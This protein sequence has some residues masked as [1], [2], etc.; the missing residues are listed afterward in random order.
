M[1]VMNNDNEPKMMVPDVR[2]FPLAQIRAGNNARTDFDENELAELVESMRESREKIGSTLQ[3]LLGRLMPDGMVELIAGER[4]MRAASLAGYEEM[5][6]KVVAGCTEA[7]VLRWNLVENLQ[8]S[9]LKPMEVARRVKE[10]LALTVD[11][12]PVYNQ[13]SLAAELG[14]SA[15]YIGWCLRALETEVKVQEAINTGRICL[16]TG[17]M[18]GALPEAMRKEAA[19]EIAFPSW[20]EPMDLHKARKHI[21]ERYRR[22][23]RK[24][25]WDKA[26]GELL[27]NVGPCTSC[28]WWGGL[29]D[30]VGGKM[31]ESVCLNPTCAD[32]KTAR[33]LEKVRQRAEDQG[34]KVLGNPGRLFQ[35]WNDELKP[36][37]GYVELKAKPDAHL[38]SKTADKAPTWEELVKGAEV[39]VVVAFDHS[40]KVRRLVETKVAVE[41]AKLGKHAQVLKAD[42]KVKGFDDKRLDQ[43][44]ERAEKKAKEQQTLLACNAL[45]EQLDPVAWLLRLWLVKQMI[46]NYTS[47]DYEWLCRVLKPDL[48]KITKPQTQLFELMESEL[49]EDGKLMAFAVI[50]QNARGIRYNGLSHLKQSMTMYVDEVGFDVTKWEANVKEAQKEAKIAAKAKVKGKQKEAAQKESKKTKPKVEE[51]GEEAD[52]LD[53]SEAE[54]MGAV[55]LEFDEIKARAR[56]LYDEGM[57]KD[58]IA[59]QLGI[60]PN[61]VGNWQ[62]RDWPKRGGKNEVEAADD[63]EGKK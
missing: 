14:K 28:Q 24:V 57:G 40:G 25:D 62:K 17:A 12:V 27:P 13:A 56:V 26:D 36:E 43:A 18:I 44:V 53:G 21:A 5:E 35:T 15:N 48:G 60:S 29:R 20:G 46:S 23:L 11:G 41:A 37:S 31:R 8:R 59:K 61:T 16:E 6:V 30:D 10:M 19:R 58:K 45:M 47:D 34:T 1:N 52:V 4:R 42:T 3:P 9:Q 7:D 2:R 51:T 54:R 49:K 50:A 55:V 32:A 38:L 63:R 33:W 22:D 39:P